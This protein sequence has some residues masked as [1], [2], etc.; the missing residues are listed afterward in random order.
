[1]WLRVACGCWLRLLGAG[2]ARSTS[3]ELLRRPAGEV[4]CGRVGLLALAETIRELVTTGPLVVELL[5]RSL[6]TG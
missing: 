1:M 2:P 4:L 6:C 5:L 3:G